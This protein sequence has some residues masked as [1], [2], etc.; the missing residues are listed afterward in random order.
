MKVIPNRVYGQVRNFAHR[1]AS[2]TKQTAGGVVAAVIFCA[3]TLLSVQAQDDVRHWD[4]QAVNANGTSAWS[5]PPGQQ[6]P[7]YSFRVTGVLLT[8]PF[9]MLD[10]T[11][12]FQPAASNTMGGQLQLVV[13]AVATNDRGGT[14]CWMGQNYAIRRPPGLDEYSYSNEAWS[15]EVW[16]V[17]HDPATG[18]AFRR[19]DLVQVVAR[20]SLFHGG[21]RNINEMHRVEPEYDFTVSLV[22][23]NY[24]LPEPEVISLLSLVRPD[25]GDPASSED[26]FDQTRA[27]G[28]EHWQG[29]RVRINGLMLVTTNGWNPTNAWGQRLCIVTDGTSRFFRL[30]HPRYDLGMPPTNW[31]DA[32]GIL[33]QESGSA[34]QGTNGY[35][36]FVQEIVPS[37]PVALQI[38]L[39]DSGQLRITWPGSLANF[40][41]QYTDDI[42]GGQL[43]WLPVTNAPVL[44]NGRWT[45]LLPADGPRRF[46]R[47]ERVR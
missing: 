33:N 47:L 45:V 32:I 12:N 4:L 46:F 23:S 31:F 10:P 35:E 21:K 2:P 39:D 20:G 30:R 26:I 3:S 8:D 43:A 7:N 28:G 11:P 9:E 18:H 24:G 13:Q 16:R 17:T 34:V 44:V 6:F 42:A 25:D 19:G 15:N 29:M 27:T 41:L 5:P 22:Q 40:Q 38:E 1:S 37:D 14:F 36:L